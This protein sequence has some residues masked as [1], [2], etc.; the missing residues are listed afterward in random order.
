MFGV[1]SFEIVLILAIALIVLGPDRLP[2]AMGT[3]GRWVRELRRLT[4]EFRQE[5]DQE[6]QLLQSEIENLRQEA[7]LTRQELQDIQTDL[8]ET[9]G[10]VQADLEEAGQDIKSELGMAEDVVRGHSPSTKPKS[11]PKTARPTENRSTGELVDPSDAMYRAIQETFAGAN[12]QTASSPLPVVPES[13]PT[14][15]VIPSP[16]APPEQMINVGGRLDTMHAEVADL[17]GAS[18]EQSV[19]RFS[20]QSEQFG[21]LLKVVATG[22]GESLTKATKELQRQ[23][24]ADAIKLAHLSGKGPAGIAL[25]WAAQRQSLVKD[26]SIE[27]DT[28]ED[29]RVRIRMKECPYGLSEGSEV[30]ICK[31]SNAYDL[32]LAEQMG[33]V[34]KYERRLT[35]MHPH[36][37]LV[38]QTP[39]MA[40]ASALEQLEE[41]ARGKTPVAVAA[42]TPE[43]LTD[44]PEAAEKVAAESD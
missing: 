17:A 1:G 20:P 30:P 19:R 44:A 8:V 26:G 33:A 34:G 6:I 18:G 32:A 27:I 15:S 25:A 41:A 38:I 2:Q 10:G 31:L 4:G 13:P 11:A 42:K 7:E 3:V 24:A 28:R 21:A 40:A 43:D 12:G 35:T 39:E 5:F 23:A 22:G 14:S 9:V 37:E 29:G 16:S 36:C